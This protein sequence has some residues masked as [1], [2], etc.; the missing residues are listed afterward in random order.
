M[1]FF[2]FNFETQNNLV[3]SFLSSA[4]LA[5]NQTIKD[6]EWFY[7]KFRDNPFGESI[8]ACAMEDNVIVGCVALGMQDFV[9]QE[10]TIKAAMS[11]ET[12]VHPNY[13]GK[14]IFKKLIDLAETES[15]NRGIKFLLNFPNS[16][17]LPGFKKSGWRSI[18]CSEYWI[19]GSDFFKILFNI[20]DI[21]KSFL[22][23]PSNLKSLNKDKLSLLND[24]NKD[25]LSFESILNEKYIEWRFF[26]YPMSEYAI[27]NNDDLF[28]I[29]RVGYRGGLKESQ[30]LTVK[31]KS[32]KNISI[33]DLIK[34]YKKKTNYD[35]IS[36]PISKKNKIRKN[37]ARLLFI[38]VPS[39]TNVTYKIINQGDQFN[40]ESIEL[41]A[42]NYHTY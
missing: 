16:N 28:S 37:I 35:I 23:N 31:N 25:N 17:S 7:W 42:I 10:N 26:K 22:P 36:F 21:R 41:S 18:D 11:F 14:G 32:Q 24:F 5:H 39:K 1:T 20:R 27:I 30:V 3:S 29:A 12:F 19:K 2:I 33:S 9:C 6:D 4:S 34:E 40:F 13:Q 15:R 38:K 8:L